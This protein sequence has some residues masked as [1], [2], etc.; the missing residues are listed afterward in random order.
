MFIPGPA[1]SPSS[2]SIVSGSNASARH[3]SSWFLA[4]EGRK[5]APTRQPDASRHARACSVG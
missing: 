3:I 5:F 4:V 2:R 1:A